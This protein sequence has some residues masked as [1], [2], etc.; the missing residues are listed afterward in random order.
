MI[1]NVQCRLL[2]CHVLT[3]A[4]LL[5]CTSAFAE[6]TGASK[7]SGQGTEGLSVEKGTKPTNALRPR[8]SDRAELDRVI[9]LYMAGRYEECSSDLS[10]FLKPG[11][12]ERFSE[13]EVIERARLYFATCAMLLGQHE[14]ARQ[15]LL[16]ALQ[17]NPLMQSPDSLTFPP[18]VVSLFLEVRDEVQQL[19]SEREREQVAQLRRENERARQKALER[20]RREKELEKLAKQ[21]PVIVRGSRFIAA[22]PFGAGQFQN[23]KPV[24]GAVFLAGESVLGITALTSGIILH[25]L[26]AGARKNGCTA[27][28]VDQ[29]NRQ[30]GAAYDTLT[31][32]TWGLLG[33]CVVGIAEAQLFFKKE[34][35]LEVRSRPL[36][37]DLRAP[38]EP[39]ENAIRSRP[40]VQVAPIVNAGPGGGFLGLS[41]RF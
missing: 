11:G 10:V 22:L 8:L 26:V 20:L 12:K 19:I 41:G 33:L 7:R 15:S 35:L 6:Q 25:A 32:S 17:E 13:P 29:Y 31:W 28:C 40:R 39:K 36:P 4:L 18:P 23:G 34:R 14:A 2:R 24:L 3:L 27:D 1:P 37:P 38:T 30:T 21:E 5:L 16:T 9:E